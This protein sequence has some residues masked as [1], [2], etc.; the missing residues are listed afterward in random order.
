MA[1]SC[2]ASSSDSARKRDGK[3]S[4]TKPM[5]WQK[6]L[7]PRGRGKDRFCLADTGL[8]DDDNTPRCRGSECCRRDCT[9]YIERVS[10]KAMDHQLKILARRETIR[11]GARPCRLSATVGDLCLEEIGRA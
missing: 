4:R 9:V 5:S 10:G 11:G 2:A 6:T 3:N 1:S 8:K 7:R